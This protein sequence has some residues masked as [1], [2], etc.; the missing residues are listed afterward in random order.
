MTSAK[1]S[2][3][4]VGT[5]LVVGLLAGAGLTQLLDGSKTAVAVEPAAA[6]TAPKDVARATPA[7]MP[8]QTAEPE[9]H[10]SLDYY[11]NEAV[12]IFD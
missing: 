8:L 1:A 11:G 4:S 5:A 12:P 7:A 3:F 2:R 9:D 10:G 6:L